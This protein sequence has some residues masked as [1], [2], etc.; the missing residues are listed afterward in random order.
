[1]DCTRVALVAGAWLC[2]TG[3][4]NNTLNLDEAGDLDSTGSATGTQGSAD[5]DGPPMVTT[6]TTA[7]TGPVPQTTT[8][9]TAT[10]DSG[11][12]SGIEDGWWL[13]ALDTGSPGLP[14]QFVV[15][16]AQTSPGVWDMTF[17]P[18]ALDVGSTTTPR[19]PVGEPRLYQGAEFSEGAPLQFYTGSL[20]I[21]GEANPVNGTPVTLDAFLDGSEAGDPY[22]GP[23]TGAVLE[24]VQADLAGSSFA[25]TRIPDPTA[26]PTDFPMAC[27]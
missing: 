13:L 16:V 9:T 27:P 19:F 21:P 2:G 8:V 5:D 22:C 17:Q 3:C 25:T 20:T 11:P 7:T 10:S 14:F 18:L 26:L 24:P 6:A 23:V 15:F 4:Q 1:M 12:W